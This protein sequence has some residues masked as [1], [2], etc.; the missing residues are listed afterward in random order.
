MTLLRIPHS[1]A[2]SLYHDSPDNIIS[3][4]PC[5]STGRAETC[6]YLLHNTELKK[7]VGH[8]TWVLSLP[9]YA[10]H[11]CDSAVVADRPVL[12]WREH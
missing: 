10:T 11:Q 9:D 7:T 12:I 2:L 4:F 1:A 3:Y 5:I 6:K 8:Y